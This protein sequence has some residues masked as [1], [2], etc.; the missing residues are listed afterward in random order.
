MRRGHSGAAI[1]AGGHGAVNAAGRGGTGPQPGKPVPQ[2]LRIQEPP[3]RADVLGG[4]RAY[5]GRDVPGDRVGRFHLTPV[6][7]RRPGVQEH[8]LAGHP[9]R[10]VRVEEGQVARAG[11]ERAGR[12]GRGGPGLDRLVHGQPGLVTAVQHPHLRVPEVAQQPPGAGGG[13]RVVLVVSHHGPVVADPGPAHRRLERCRVRQG[14]ASSRSG[15]AG[16]IAVQVHEVGARQ[17]TL[18]ETVDPGRPAEPPPDIQQDRHR[19]GGQCV[20][21]GRGVDG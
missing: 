1:H 16:Q 6:A 19:A 18:A 12:R 15:R 11:G 13:R 2:R 4:G 14:V 9:G 8:A 10:P 17:V 7:L 3:A 21:E 20:R 5:R